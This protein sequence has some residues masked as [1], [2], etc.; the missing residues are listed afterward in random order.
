MNITYLGTNTLLFH[1]GDTSI[2]VDPHFSRP[3]MLNLLGKIKPDPQ[4]IAENLARF[5]IH[6][7][8]GILLTHTHYDHALDAAEVLRQTGGALF[9]SE[10]A[11]NLAQGAGLDEHACVQVTL[12]Q[13][14]AIGGLPIRFHPARHVEF[15]APMRWLMPAERQISQP[16]HPPTWFWRY[17]AGHTLA[18]QVGRTLVFGS[19]GFIPGAYQDLEVETVILGI[20]G[21]DLKSPIYLHQFYRETVLGSGARQVFLSHWDNFFGPPGRTRRPMLLARRSIAR[22]KALG[23]RYGQSVH[24]LEFGTTRLIG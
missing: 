21:L 20:G 10:S 1:Q 6:R 4:I 23:I 7:L 5:E 17:Q 9:G 18:I 8:D 16:L 19:A 15:P 2:L 14:F 12:Q 3:G 22:I 13:V 11:I 24:Q